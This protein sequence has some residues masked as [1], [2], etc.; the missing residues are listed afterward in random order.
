MDSEGVV[1]FLRGAT[2]H[3]P[4]LGFRASFFTAMSFAFEAGSAPAE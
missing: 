2:Q 4:G 1:V 3:A